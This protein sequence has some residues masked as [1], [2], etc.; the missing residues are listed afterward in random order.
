VSVATR[1]TVITVAYNAEASIEQ[2]ILSV[3]AQS[4]PGIEYLVI[5]GA[6]SDGTVEI[7]RRHARHIS[8]WVSEPDQGIYDAMNKGIALARGEWIL[9]LNADD[10]FRDANSAQRLLAA[11]DSSVS[12]VAGRT[13][14]KYADGERIFHPSRRFGLMLQLPFMHPSAIVRRSVFESCGSFDRRYSLAAD[15][16]FFLR[17]IAR[18][19]RHRCIDDVVTV[20]RHGGASTRGFV[21][22]R[23]EYMAAYMRNMHDPV[24]ACAG[25]ALSMLMKLKAR[26]R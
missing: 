25:F 21:R 18:G 14:M 3:A 10:Y 13:L 24:G 5:D 20:M 26:L 9:F 4:A 11:A 12:I 6:S 1:L 22:G 19:H 2:T 15:C 23:L 16:D 7:L 8:H 17:L